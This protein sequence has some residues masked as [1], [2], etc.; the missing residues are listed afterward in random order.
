LP[1]RGQ[2]FDASRMIF[3][4]ALTLCHQTLRRIDYRNL[5]AFRR[6]PHTGGGPRRVPGR[7]QSIL[8]R[9]FLG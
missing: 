7:I 5:H 6:I 2:R 9:D 3:H 8:R 4:K 1:V